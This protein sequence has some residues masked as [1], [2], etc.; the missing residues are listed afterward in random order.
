VI[1]SLSELRDLFVKNNKKVN[2]FV[3][4]YLKVGKDTYTMLDS[5]VYKNQTKLSNKEV[6]NMFKKKK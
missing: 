5:E 3:G 1:N 2:Q 4:W 6:L